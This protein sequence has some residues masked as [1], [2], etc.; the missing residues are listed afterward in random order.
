MIV[1]VIMS[2]NINTNIHANQNTCTFVSKMTNLI[3]IN[4]HLISSLRFN[5]YHRVDTSAGGLLVPEC[6]IPPIVSVSTL[7]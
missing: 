6:I 3:H 7:T 1:E 4:A 2:R 5:H